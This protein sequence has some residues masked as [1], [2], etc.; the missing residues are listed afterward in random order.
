MVSRSVFDCD[1]AGENIQSDIHTRAECA[2]QAA[3]PGEQ[4]P[5]R[6]TTDVV[7][8]TLFR[9]R[10][11][12]VQL[13]QVSSTAHRKWLPAANAKLV[14]LDDNAAVDEVV[15]EPLD[16]RDRWGALDVGRHI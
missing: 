2:E 5:P 11:P 7:Q 9:D 13:P 8:V 16:R 4:C 10:Q 12:F 6:A 3:R 1:P 15:V 14:E